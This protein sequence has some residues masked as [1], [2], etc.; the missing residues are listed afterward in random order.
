MHYRD[1]YFKWFIYDH[2]YY[3]KTL[4]N[5]LILVILIKFY[6][7]KEKLWKQEEENQKYKLKVKNGEILLN[8]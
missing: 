2:M 3:D 7:K 5:V 4:R 6:K 8:S 1:D